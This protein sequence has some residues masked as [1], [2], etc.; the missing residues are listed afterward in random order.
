MVVQDRGR[1]QRWHTFCVMR[2]CFSPGLVVT[3]NF[4]CGSVSLQSYPNSPVNVRV[5]MLGDQPSNLT[6]PL[7]ELPIRVATWKL[8][9]EVAQ[10]VGCWGWRRVSALGCQ[11]CAAFSVVLECR[12][13]KRKTNP[14]LYTSL[15][16]VTERSV[17]K[18]KTSQT[19]KQTPVIIPAL[20]LPA[21]WFC[22]FQF[23]RSPLHHLQ[24]GIKS[25]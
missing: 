18:R 24:N 25:N 7:S 14:L 16:R 3:A 12:D 19:R 13:Y 15:K 2:V 8:S 4:T 5:G 1:G 20:V 9:V 6:S 22:A 17:L 23:F 21:L 11:L 10:S